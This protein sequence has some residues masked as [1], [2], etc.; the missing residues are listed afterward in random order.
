MKLNVVLL[1]Q[2]T[3]RLIKTIIYTRWEFYI[4]SL[5]TITALTALFYHEI[6]NC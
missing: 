1:K 2:Q 6:C 3:F 4:Y 5:Q